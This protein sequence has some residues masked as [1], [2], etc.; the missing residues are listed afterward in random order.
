[1]KV[2]TSI[3]TAMSDGV[4]EQVLSWCCIPLDGSASSEVSA[5]LASLD[6]LGPLDQL[7]IRVIAAEHF[8]AAGSIEDGASVSRP[9]RHNKLAENWYLNYA[10]RIE[11]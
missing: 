3:D 2:R 7:K 1:M 6:R 5:A 8:A 9:L 10:K 4:T 11:R